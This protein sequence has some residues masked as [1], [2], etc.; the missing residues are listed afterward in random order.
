MGETT[1]AILVKGDVKMRK[2]KVFEKRE[3]SFMWI[4]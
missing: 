3:H 2:E 1:L 4:A